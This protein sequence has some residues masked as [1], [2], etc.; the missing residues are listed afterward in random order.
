MIRGKSI[1][2]TGLEEI[3]RD[4]REDYFDWVQV[5]ELYRG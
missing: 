4:I 1:V 2:A 3:D 5:F